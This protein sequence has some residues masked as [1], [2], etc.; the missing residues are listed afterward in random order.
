MNTSTI[1]LFTT[2]IILLM[3][4]TIIKLTKS[5]K[6]KKKN[7]LIAL[8]NNLKKTETKFDFYYI[9]SFVLKYR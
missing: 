4:K 9:F 3:A 6:L 2:N 7:H 5:A 8:T 1:T